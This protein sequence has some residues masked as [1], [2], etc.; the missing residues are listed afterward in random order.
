MTRYC[1]GKGFFTVGKTLLLK[2]SGCY[3]NTSYCDEMYEPGSNGLLRLPPNKF[4]PAAI[5]LLACQHGER[6]IGVLKSNGTRFA[7]ATH[8]RGTYYMS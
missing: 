6:A 1:L 2:Q 8:F 3:T 4:D 5:D 7:L